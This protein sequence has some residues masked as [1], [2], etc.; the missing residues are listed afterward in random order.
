ML[1]IEKTNDRVIHQSQPILIPE[2]QKRPVT[3]TK[4]YSQY[5]IGDRIYNLLFARKFSR[6]EK[7]C[8]PAT[9]QLLL[10]LEISDL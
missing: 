5:A 2:E 10:P 6:Q 1:K 7:D 9:P 8:A 4:G 3:E